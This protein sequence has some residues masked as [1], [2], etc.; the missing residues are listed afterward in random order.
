MKH[1]AE[2]SYVALEV[3]M[4]CNLD[5][6]HCYNSWKR[7]GG[8]RAAE[9]SFG[10]LTSTVRRLLRQARVKQITLTGGEP[11]MVP[12]LAEVALQCRLQGASVSII[13]NGTRATATDYQTLIDLG[14]RMFQFP[15][16]APEPAA[17]DWLLRSPGAWQRSL[18]AMRSVSQLGGTAVGVVV[19]TPQNAHLVGQTMEQLASAG[20]RRVMVNRFNEGGRGIGQDQ[21]LVPTPT[22]LAR[23]FDQANRAAPRLGLSVSS[24]VCVPGCVLD[25]RAYPRIRFSGCTGDPARMPLTLSA[26]GDLRLCNHSPVV[27][28]NIFARPVARLLRSD[29]VQR[30]G[31]TLPVRCQGCGELARCRGGCKAAAE[32][33]GRPEGAV[34]PYV[35]RWGRPMANNESMVG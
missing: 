29:Y 12:R 6:R 13:S 3:T 20:V 31:A 35:E 2:L 8:Q 18:G 16:H 10:Q 7:P 21:A 19:V 1:K 34:D 4:R 27:L 14:V 5:C 26:A 30:F 11:F 15:L 32:Q 33:L 25:T 17:H 28:G 23:A 9:A 24:N 22:Q